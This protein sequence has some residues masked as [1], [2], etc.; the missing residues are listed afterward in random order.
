MNPAPPRIVYVEDDENDVLFLQRAFRRA[1]LEAEWAILKEG[2]AAR[3]CLAS[4]VC[5]RASLLILD[6][7]LPLLTGLE[8]LGWWREHAPHSPVPIVILTSSDNEW[9][10]A[11]ARELGAVHYLLKPTTPAGYGLVAQTL[12]KFVRANAG[13]AR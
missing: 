8:L 7:N 3:D 13:G 10:Q 11:R 2:A 6:L 4:G 1:G 9:D 5:E 12:A